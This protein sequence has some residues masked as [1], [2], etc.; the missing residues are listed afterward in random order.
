[1]ASTQ[2]ATL[3]VHRVSECLCKTGDTA[4]TDSCSNAAM[5]LLMKILYVIIL[6][7]H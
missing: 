4:V 3:R 5:D 7:V 6:F 1:M 2:K